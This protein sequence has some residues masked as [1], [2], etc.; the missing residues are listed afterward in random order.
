[1]AE[2]KPPPEST[3]SDERPMAP[4]QR[5]STAATTGAFVT[6]VGDPMPPVPPLTD[7]ELA[8]ASPSASASVG[9]PLP[10]PPPE[11]PLYLAMAPSRR[12][13]QNVQRQHF[14]PLSGS[15][16]VTNSDPTTP[17]DNKPAS[18]TLSPP[19]KQR[20]A[21]EPSTSQKDATDSTPNMQL[22]PSPVLPRPPLF[23]PPQ[24]QELRAEAKEHNP[25]TILPLA[26]VTP[27]H[28][29]APS[30]TVAT[31]QVPRKSATVAD[32]TDVTNRP[33]ETQALR[34]KSADEH[35]LESAHVRQFHLQA[36]RRERL[37]KTAQT[38]VIH[39]SFFGA[40][41]YF[42]TFGPTIQDLAVALSVSL[43]R[44]LFLLAA[45]G[46][47]FFLGAVVSGVCLRIVNAQVSLMVLDFFLAMA[48]IGVSYFDTL[49]QSELLF[50]LGGLALG[51][52]HIIGVLWVLSLWREASGFMIQT[53]S[54]VYCIG[55]VLGPVV[56]EPFMTQR[57]VLQPPS[58]LPP[59]K[60]RELA[61]LTSLEDKDFIYVAYAYWLVGLYVFAVTFLALASFF[62]HP[63][64]QDLSPME[65]ECPVAPCTG[66]VVMLV[67][68]LATYVA[69]ETIYGQLIA[70]FT[71]LLGHNKT[72]AAYVTSLFWAAFTTV[73]GVSIMW[74]KQQ[75]SF[76]VLLCCNVLLVV[77][78]GVEAVFGHQTQ[79]IWL[80]SA[81]V[82][83]CIAPVMPS[84]LLL[85][86]D[87]LGVSRR[88]FALVMMA[89]GASSA[90]AP[91]VVGAVMESEPMLFHYSI[92]G[93]AV[94]LLL[95]IMIGRALV[96]RT[97]IE[98]GYALV[99]TDEQRRPSKRSVK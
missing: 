83:A 86:H 12:S 19:P 87:Y 27:P 69:V 21:L 25:E 46:L 70:A 22:E 95:L 30:P 8:S 98:D 24:R 61:Y 28:A 14:S 32:V 2:D 44:V 48:C 34:R 31:P 15:S 1:M 77:V 53:L 57:S 10:P 37:V 93:L 39:F 73:R 59:P 26:N 84:T 78:A 9:E 66:L 20:N 92:A 7:S 81:L 23:S 99:P 5:G 62:I 13:A 40:G 50:A 72:T 68:Y 88:R 96:G 38:L 58:D 6:E 60:E 43:S 4:L 45:R 54:F 79:V 80:G 82:G 85:L 67:F 89:V 3:S 18:G 16:P 36:S 71:L 90:F 49:L 94:I 29:I 74:L 55:C 51:G 17:G 65:T 91:L 42:A 64:H 56:G 47:G 75:G 41:M 97:A 35:I 33:P 11:E 52:I 63:R 76:N